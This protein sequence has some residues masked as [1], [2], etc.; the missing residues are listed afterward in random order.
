MIRLVSVEGVLGQNMRTPPPQ[1]LALQQGDTLLMYTD[2]VSD[3]FS[4]EDYPAMAS[5]APTKIARNIVERF[6][7]AH[8]D[9]ACL[10]V[11]VGHD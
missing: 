7:K 9:A 10:V 2:G 4:R 6:G 8:D 11:S 3:R 1:Q 5:H